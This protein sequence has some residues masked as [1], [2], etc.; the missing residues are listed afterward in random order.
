MDIS[1]GL[2]QVIWAAG[3]SREEGVDQNVMAEKV[4]EAEVV[5]QRGLEVWFGL[6]VSRRGGDWHE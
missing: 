1:N 3:R 6:M 5:L 2:T 4:M